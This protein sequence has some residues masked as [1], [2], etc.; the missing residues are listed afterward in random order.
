MVRFPRRSDHL[1]Q[2]YLRPWWNRPFPPHRLTSQSKLEPR[3]LVKIIL[4]PFPAGRK[5]F[6]NSRPK[7]PTGRKGLQDSPAKVTKRHDG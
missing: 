7:F 1:V 2:F 6:Y 3:L 4:A 5:T